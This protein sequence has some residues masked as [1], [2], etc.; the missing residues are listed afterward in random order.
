MIVIL[1]LFTLSEWDMRL[2]VKYVHQ[3]ETQLQ[4]TPR[5]VITYGRRYKLVFK[6]FALFFLFFLKT[7][8]I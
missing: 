4:V 2:F 8:N 7:C 1:T 3:E 5:R 6:D